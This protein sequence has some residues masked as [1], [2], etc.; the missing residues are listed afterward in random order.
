[1]KKIIFLEGLPG[2]GKTTIIKNIESR[3]LPGVYTMDEIVE[4]NIKNNVNS[5]NQ[6]FYI[7]ND[8]LK[9]NKYKEGIIIIDRGPISTLA[10]NI[11]KSKLNN[12]FSSEEVELWFD[13]IKNIYNEN[14]RV[15]FLNN[16]DGYYIPYE[17]NKDPYGSIENQKMLQ[18]I[19]L[20]IIRKYVKDY[21]IKDYKKEDMERFINEIIN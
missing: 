5:S 18:E 3:Q 7:N 13:K 1:M 11:V 15:I 14:T 10:Y 16:T 4:P 2:V 12:D 19:T 9:I 6:N 20:D 8:N 21:K 17:D